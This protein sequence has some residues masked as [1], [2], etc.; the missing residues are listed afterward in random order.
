MSGRPPGR[1]PGRGALRNAV[2][3]PLPDYSAGRV[4]PG[5][6]VLV[7]G[8]IGEGH[9]RAV[10][11][12]LAKEGAAVAV[13]DSTGRAGLPPG[14]WPLTG[15]A[16]DGPVAA[17]GRLLSELGACSLALHCDL[18]NESDCRGAAAH[19]ALEFGAIDTLAICARTES[20]AG[21]PLS[22]AGGYGG[23]A[24]RMPLHSVLWL[25][26]AAQVFMAEGASV[27]LMGPEAD[28]SGP[29]DPLDAAAGASGAAGL[30]R[31]LAKA[32]QGRGVRVNCVVPG[33][34]GPGDIAAAY[35]DLAGPS[36]RHGTGGVLPVAE[37]L[38]TRICA[39]PNGGR[40][41][42]DEGV[43]NRTFGE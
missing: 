18:L 36:G 31:S 37:V 41:T 3:D 2:P 12:A 7:A 32:L 16:E 23:Y 42:R 24:P 40:G 4:L 35:V 21:G 17:T 1:A 27:V 28:R 22:G 38:R 34:D 10:A 9:G 14:A 8:G 25:V 15:H 39:A 6:R 5:R 29:S 13:A 30:T 19:T 20:G 33:L 26:R 43:R 11:V